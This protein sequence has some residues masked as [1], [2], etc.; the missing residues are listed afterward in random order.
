MKNTLGPIP[1]ILLVLI[2]VAGVYSVRASRQGNPPSEQTV[3]TQDVAHCP[4]GT[5]VGRVAPSCEFAACPGA[6]NPSTTASAKI[7]EKATAS[8]VTVTPLEITGDSR[9][10]VDVTCIQAGTVVA[11]VKM[12]SGNTSQASVLGLGKSVAFGS[13]IVAFTS[14]T[15]VKNSKITL[16]PSDYR[17]TFE[18]TNEIAEGTLSG[19]VTIGPVCPVEKIGET[20]TPTAEMYAARK[21]NIYKPE[22]I[23]S[24]FK[25]LTPDSKV[26]SR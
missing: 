21:V 10:P 15:P 13:K 25:I 12:E 8:G 24:P 11:R 18:V 9:C 14:V 22:D 1:I 2:A 5:Y 23:I 6:N 19:Q 17:L 20:C 7:G 26:N 16:K 4:D 3:C